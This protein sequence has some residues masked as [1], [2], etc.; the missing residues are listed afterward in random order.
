LTQAVAGTRLEGATERDLEMRR[1]R[2]AMCAVVCML[3]AGAV[4]CGVEDDDGTTATTV[5]GQTAT[6]VAGQS[7]PLATGKQFTAADLEKIAV[8]ASDLPSDYLRV[9]AGT[10]QKSP[11][12]CVGLADQALAAQM[13]TFGLESCYEAEFERKV[14]TDANNVAST[15]SLF[16][17]PASASR[18]MLVLRAALASATGTVAVG[19]GGPTD[20]PVAALGDEATAGFKY[21]TDLFG[22]R[23]TAYAYVWRT[24]NVVGFF[25]GSDVLGDLSEASILDIAKKVAARAPA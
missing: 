3:A 20:L 10:G 19:G 17:D 1:N 16:R 15:S 22:K 5:A 12:E 18:A 9:D 7:T 23:A 24:G 21:V 14:G 13:A 25:G 2:Y 11:Q 4:G 8:Q 6:T